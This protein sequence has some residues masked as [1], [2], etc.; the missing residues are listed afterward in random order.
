MIELMYSILERGK[1]WIKNDQGRRKNDENGLPE[2]AIRLIQHGKKT[3]NFLEEANTINIQAQEDQGSK[4]SSNIDD[5]GEKDQAMLSGVSKRVYI[6]SGSILD[7][8]AASGAKTS[9]KIHKFRNICI[10]PGQALLC[11]SAQKVTS[12]LSIFMQPASSC[13]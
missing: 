1:R 6:R 3:V 11:I 9:V 2:L 8:R 4:G 13:D 12:L 5:S 10:P 7:R